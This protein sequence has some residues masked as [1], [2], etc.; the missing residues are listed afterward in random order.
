MADML[1]YLKWRGD[2]LFSELPLNAVD[3]LIFSTLS[4]VGYDGIVSEEVCR[5]ITLEEA[6]RN[7]LELPDL[8]KRIRV[9]RDIELLE[10]VLEAPRFHRIGMSFYQNILIPE[11]DTQF[12]A[13]TF[14]LEDGSAFLAFRG[15]DFTLTGWKEDF[16]MS[17]QESVPAQRLAVKY[18]QE[19]CE[20]NSAPLYLGGHSKGGNLAVYA[21]AKCGERIQNRIMKV[22]NQDGPGFTSNLMGDSNYQKMIPKI[23]TYIPQSSVVGMLLEHEEPYTVIRSKQIGFLQHDPYSWEIMRKDFI[24]LEEVS[25]ESQLLDKTIKAWMMEMSEEDRDKLVDTVFELLMKG[26]IE[27]TKEMLKPK[28]LVNYLKTLKNDDEMRHFLAGEL[29]KLIRSAKKQNSLE[30]QN[31]TML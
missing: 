21:A 6:V 28:S 12:S 18:V 13:V 15:T 19:F 3:A 30:K 10:A 9:K 2:I 17:F 4:Y 20:V 14:Y 5:W 8:E 7:V 16:N 23:H 1:D 11:E 24:Y 27:T 26:D 29:T 22:Y 25:A 31:N